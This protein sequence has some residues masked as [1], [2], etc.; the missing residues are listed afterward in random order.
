[1]REQTPEQEEK[2]IRNRKLRTV[3]IFT[4]AIL[5]TVIIVADVCLLVDHSKSFSE[6]E[7]R[8]LQ[9]APV[10]TRSNLTSG[11]F[12]TQAEDF[13]ADQFFLRSGWISMRL[14]ADRIFGKKESNGVYLGKNGCLIEQA[15]EPDEKNFE[16]NLKAIA[17]FADYYPE[18]SMV[19][20][21]VPNAFY[22]CDQLVPEGATGADQ[23]QILAR[24]DQKVGSSVTFVNLTEVMKSHKEEYIYYKSDHHWTSL[25]A[26]YAF[27]SLTSV[28][29]ITEPIADYQMMYVSNDFSGTL[30][31]TSGAVGIRDEIAIYV[32]ET[33]LEYVTDYVDDGVKS[34]TMY[35]SA[36]LQNQ[37]Q[38]EVFLGGNHPLITISTNVIN[39]RTLLILKDSYAN[40]F[41]QFL[42]PYY[43]SILIVDPRYYSDNLRNLI[44]QNAVTDVLLLYNVNTFVE[45]NSLSIVLEDVLN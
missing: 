33:D 17:S 40:S 37:N 42:L 34:A 1:M 31:S 44:S 36:A 6:S 28:L 43:Q 11:R 7:N 14:A 26:K 39:E 32:P 4:L 20:V 24:M 41:I 18:I 16:R 30:S 19:M 2:K 27:D 21:M 8:M 15:K 12:M 3:H 25:G 23:G 45:D 5:L 38:Y 9:Q 35:N 10:L 29:N 22:I 13:I